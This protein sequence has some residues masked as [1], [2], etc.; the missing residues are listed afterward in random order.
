LKWYKI[1]NRSQKNSHSC[2]P[3]KA[4]KHEIF[5]SG[6]FKQIIPI[7]KGD[8]GTR[9]EI[10]EV[11]GFGLKIEILNAKCCKIPPNVKEIFNILI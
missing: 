1:Q 3:L 4:P 2:V 11:Y 10:Q 5:G 9:P 8:L 7:W 6:V